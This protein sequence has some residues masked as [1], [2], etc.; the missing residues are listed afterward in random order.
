MNRR[1]YLVGGGAMAVAGAGAAYLELRGMGSMEEYRAS[2]AAIRMAL[3][4]S[5]ETSD[6]IR[7]APLAA[8]SHNT[9]PWR[10]R[11]S[12]G[13][14][15]LRSSTLTITICSPVSAARRKTWPSPAVRAENR[16]SS[17][18]TRHMTVP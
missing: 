15:G 14:I 17:V 5:P 8:N 11:I 10:F 3:K 9:Q 4:Q 7:Y 2:V 16:A 12:D 13:G 1:Q 18:L 6:L